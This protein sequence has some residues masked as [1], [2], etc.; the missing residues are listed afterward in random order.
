MTNDAQGTRDGSVIGPPIGTFSFMSVG[1][2]ETL[3][4]DNS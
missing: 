3:L 1:E 2:A 4:T